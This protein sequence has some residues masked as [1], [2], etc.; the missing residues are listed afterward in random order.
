MKQAILA[1]SVLAATLLWVSG[2]AVGAAQTTNGGPV[3]A[4]APDLALAMAFI[5]AGGGPGDFS[6][7]RAIDRSF[8]AAVTQAGLQRLAAQYGPAARDRFVET[9][10]FAI[11]DAWVRA[12]QHNLHMPAPPGVTGRPLA[13][14]LVRAGTASDGAFWSHVFLDRTLSEPVAAA[15]LQDIDARYGPG[16]SAQFL[17]TANRFF[18][19]LSQRIGA[20]V[21]LAPVH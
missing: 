20:G 11:N 1:A 6:T 21:A 10:D 13:N 4:G 15:V 7:V 14:E 19:D 3:Y 2:S 12:G 18:F 8:G 16:S 17:R 9:F 5:D